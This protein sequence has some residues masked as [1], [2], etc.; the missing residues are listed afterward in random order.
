M[1][2]GGMGGGGMCGGGMG[3]GGRLMLRWDGVKMMEKTQLC[4]GAVILL[5]PLTS[6]DLNYVCE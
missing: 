2:G 3:G 6:G 4:S 5:Q 1:G